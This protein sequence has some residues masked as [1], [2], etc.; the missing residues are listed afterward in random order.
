MDLPANFPLWTSRRVCLQGLPLGPASFPGPPGKLP[1]MDLPTGLPPGAPPWP[2]F[3]PWTSRQ[4]SPYGPPH[5]FASRG[6]PL[7]PASF[8]GPPGTFPLMDLPT[9]LPPGAP[10][11][12]CFF[13][14]TSRHISPYGPPDGFASRG[15]PLALLLS[16]DLPANL[17]LWTSRRVCLQG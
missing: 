9:G 11:W 1:L 17:P 6:Y 7:G 4:I 15:S 14:W 13:P 16:M 5:G 12:P 3:F 10:P 2:C 8:H